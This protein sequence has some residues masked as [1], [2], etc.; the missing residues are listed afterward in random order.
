MPIH[1]RLSMTEFAAKNHSILAIDDSPA[2]LTALKH[3]L[4]KVKFRVVAALTLTEGLEAARQEPLDMAL[5][6]VML[7]DGNDLDFCRR[8]KNDLI[9]GQY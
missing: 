1:P 7:P 8:I 4:D 2:I 5:L 9:L 3:L 6:D